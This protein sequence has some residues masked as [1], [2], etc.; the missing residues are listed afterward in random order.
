ME[1]YLQKVGSFLQL[2][3]TGRMFLAMVTSHLSCYVSAPHHLICF[4][5]KKYTIFISHYLISCFLL[6]ARASQADSLKNSSMK[7][8]VFCHSRF[9]SGTKAPCHYSF[10]FIMSTALKFILLNPHNFQFIQPKFIMIPL[11]LNISLFSM[12]FKSI[13]YHDTPF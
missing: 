12:A 1:A 9:T 7:H 2:N 6:Y 4:R 5:F 3:I 10:I 8:L 11:T 13:I